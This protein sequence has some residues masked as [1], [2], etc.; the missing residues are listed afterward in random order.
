VEGN[1]KRDRHP[2]FNTWNHVIPIERSRLDGT[3]I[4]SYLADPR[5]GK[6]SCVG[7]FWRETIGG[8]CNEIVQEPGQL[9][10]GSFIFESEGSKAPVRAL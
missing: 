7:A 3:D 5:A 10:K 8:E 2:F 4:P 1:E 6:H 9:G